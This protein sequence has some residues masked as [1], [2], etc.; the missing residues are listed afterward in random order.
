MDGTAENRRAFI[1]KLAQAN[2]RFYGTQDGR[3]ALRAFEL[4]FEHR[5]IYLY[6]LVQNALDAGAHSIALRITDDGDALVFQHNGER[7]IGEREVEGLSKIFRST[8]GASTVGFMGIGFKSVFGRFREALISGWGWT[9]RYE[10]PQEAGRIYGDVQP[11]ILG[12]V[13]PIW[14]DAITKPAPGFTTRFE[15]RRRV[16]RGA[17]F[18]SDLTRFLPVDDRT[19]LAI[20][21]ASGLQR[22]DVDGRVWELDIN[23][24]SDGNLEATA[25]STHEHLRWHLFP[26]SFEPSKEAI[27]CFLEHRRIRPAPDEQ[28]QVYADAARARR[29]LGVL[30][31]DDAGRPAPAA[32]G[33]IYATLPTD[34]TIPFG[35]HIDADWLLNI[36]RSGLRGIADNQWQREIADRIADILASFIRWVARTFSEQD[37]VRAAFRALA[38]PASEREGLEALLAGERWLSRLR[39][40]LADEAVFPVWTAETS[41]LTFAKPGD[42]IVPPAPLA[43]TFEAQPALQPGVL[44]KGPV[45]RN[46]VLGDRAV[47][48][49]RRI[50]LLAVI[51][52]HELARVWQDGLETWW[53]LLPGDPA[54]RPFLLFHIWAAIAELGSEDEWGA[55]ELPCVRTVSGEWVPVSGVVYFNEAF[56]TEDEPGGP[57]TR[58]FI[59][60]FI[61]DA[62]RLPN[63]WINALRRGEVQ[64][65]KGGLL[66]QARRWVEEHAQ[67]IGLKE[68][69]QDAVH[70]LRSSPKPDWSVLVPLGHWAK[71]RNRTDLLTDVLVDSKIGLKGVPFGEALLAD[72][73]VERGR[74]RRR[75]FPFTPVIAATYLERDPKNVAPRE[76]RAFL[77][78]AGA[79]GALEIRLVETHVGRWERERVAEFLGLEEID[80]IPESNGD[81][82]RLSDFEIEPTLPGPGAPEEVRAVLA[83]W[84]DDGSNVLKAK[85]RRQGFCFYHV[86]HN[87]GGIVPSAWVTKLAEL[88]WVPGDDGELKRPRHVL[89][90]PD[91]AREDA[92]VAR[93]SSALVSVL[94]QE[95]M[96]FGTAIPEAPSL[97]RL[98]AVGSR[99]DAA[100]LA[101][102]LRE[103][104]EQVTTDED[105]SH[106]EQAVREL[107]VPARDNG[108][109]PL[110]RIVRRVGRSFRGALGGWIVALDHIEE[111]LRS[112]LAHPDFPHVF[113]DTTTGEQ[114]LSYLQAVWDRASSSPE[115]L[116]NDVRNALPSAYAY[117]LKDCAEDTSLSGRWDAAVPDAAVFAEREWVVLTEADAVYFDDIND[118]RF[119]PGNMQLRTVTS[120]HLGNSRSEQLHTAQALGLRL[121]SSSVEMAWRGEDE[122]LPVTDEW[123]SRFDLICSLLR[124]VRSSERVESD[125]AGIET[126]TELRL[127]RVRG[128]ALEVSIGRSPAERVPVNARMHEEVLTL[129]GRPVQFSADA[130][131]E[132]LQHFS[133]GQRGDLAADLAGMMG[134][135]DD[136][137]DFNL[138]I[139]KFRRAF[140]PDFALP[141][142]FQP[143]SS[144]EETDTPAR[145]TAQ[146]PDPIEPKTASRTDAGESETRV[147]NSTDTEQDEIGPPIPSGN[148]EIGS[149][150]GSF[151]KDRALAAQNAL[152]K[153][154]KSALKGEIAPSDDAGTA[155]QEDRD[156]G[157]GLGDETYRSIV[158]QYERESGREPEIGDPHQTGWDI[159][160][161]DPKTEDI[162]LIEVKGKGRPWTED[163]VVELSRA[164]VREAFAASDGRTKGSW[165][166]YVVEK[167]NDG[168]YQVLPVPNPVD[169][170]AKWILS[171]ESWRLTAECP[172]RIA[173]SSK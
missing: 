80:K 134:A 12:A 86:R 93:L 100:G 167:L 68:V 122:T 77:E 108:R 158:A 156:S 105:R 94:E 128:L 159:S 8:K 66:L 23:E 56:P 69:V 132:L 24:E 140:A 6:E 88:A 141:S 31:L 171:G 172:K 74:D 131:K 27:A 78:K 103:C 115:G 114:A 139:D 99:L 11:D 104:R 101:S 50:D 16:E 29:V 32:V 161:V 75:L 107:R 65:R 43:K 13:L 61:P 83:A 162:R 42:T 106:F 120:G 14:D 98:S 48:L 33:R 143:E 72:P 41:E 153:K 129:S 173:N 113:P 144:N 126:G 47:E 3:G 163:E 84:L 70:A 85:G 46:E 151:T 22:L 37:A 7:R 118:R 4:T 39:D 44:L 58:R 111:T 154:L 137:T 102:L 76:W 40:C 117:C 71:H 147:S 38:P 91:P 90:R 25:R 82:Y 166:L 124:R 51:S 52:P 45:L 64:E 125:G 136:S 121:L 157:A 26:S 160:S 87:F 62:R 123:V 73:Y 165:Y 133:F 67:G 21:A 135:I 119:L 17:D 9:F 97:R 168:D 28:E 49:F 127:S 130:A 19:S 18:Q 169:V 59:Q 57:E 155:P 60:P 55:V 150:S 54:G 79:K 95:G 138:A 92:P 110:D 5:W 81:G 164:Q 112:E 152:A 148:D 63:T 53:E 149:A 30:S 96:Q 36:S 35:L 15:M 146:G 1:A 10:I 2:Q 170:A 20:L 116:A 109:M 142:S 34:V 89:S 145:E